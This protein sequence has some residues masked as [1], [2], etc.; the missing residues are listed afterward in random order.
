MNSRLISE[1]T[2]YLEHVKDRLKNPEIIITK[3]MIVISL[4]L[5]AGFFLRAYGNNFGL[6]M[7]FHP[8]EGAIIYRAIRIAQTG[9]L[10]PHWFGYPSLLIYI[11]AMI[12]KIELILDQLGLIHTDHAFFYLSGRF[13]SAIFGSLTLLAVYYIGK[14]LYNVQTGIIAAIFLAIMPLAVTNSHYATTDTLLTFFLVLC[15]IFSAFIVKNNK[16]KYYVLAGVAAGSATSIKYP[17]LIIIFSIFVAHLLSSIKNRNDYPQKSILNILLDKNLILSLALCGLTF[18]IG[19]P[20]S[21]IDFKKF[22]A[23][24]ILNINAS[25]STWGPIFA[26][27]APGWI[28]HLESTFPSAMTI[29]LEILSILGILFALVHIILNIKEINKHPNLQSGILL[30]SWVLPYYIYIGS[31]GLKFNR[32]TLPLLPFFALLAAKFLIDVV[33]FI[34]IR[35]P[36]LKQNSLYKNIFLTIIVGIIIV[37]PLQ[38]SISIA[39]NFAKVDTRQIA[40]NWC[41][42]NMP[43]NSTV[44][45]ESMYTPEVCRIKGIRCKDFSINS[46]MCNS[47]KIL[48]SGV[49]YFILSSGIYGR[50]FSHPKEAASTI[51]LYNLLDDN[52]ELIKVFRSSANITGPEIKIYKVPEYMIN[53]SNCEAVKVPLNPIAPVYTN[54]TLQAGKN[55]IIKISSPFHKWDSMNEAH[56][57]HSA[58]EQ[59]GDAPLLCGKELLLDDMPMNELS[60]MNNGYHADNQSGYPYQT[61]F[62]GIGERLKLQ[63]RDAKKCSWSEDRGFL[64]VMII[65]KNLSE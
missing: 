25:Q 42:V 5:I 9:D 57:T 60:M 53:I 22:L 27:T 48:E 32:Y 31:W 34:A 12:F 35:I 6:P 45:R 65:P 13:L 15:I 37:S 8:D 43:K 4:I 14:I 30:L 52:C 59:D 50:Y 58:K 41:E 28:Y 47:S 36:L 56:D 17:G 51:K 39:E 11:N 26:G 55:Y 19:T 62:I 23:D 20:F 3:Q 63:I 16:L 64:R 49:D 2:S 38:S 1:I 40:M 29:N 54:M 33:N 61:P 10:N 46:S 21:L 24:F 18:F 7:N 44:L